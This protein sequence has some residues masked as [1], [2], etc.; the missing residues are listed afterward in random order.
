MLVVSKIKYYIIFSKNRKVNHNHR[1]KIVVLNNMPNNF[2]TVIR[3]KQSDKPK[4]KKHIVL[5]FKTVS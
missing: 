1:H 3:N 5:P 2:E 4:Q